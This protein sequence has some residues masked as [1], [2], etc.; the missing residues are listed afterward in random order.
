LKQQREPCLDCEANYAVLLER[1]RI[2]IFDKKF[3]AK[4]NPS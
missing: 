1:N 2:N 3:V 4:P